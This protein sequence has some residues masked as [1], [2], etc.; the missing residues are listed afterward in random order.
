VLYTSDFSVFMLFTLF[1]VCVGHVGVTESPLKRCVPILLFIVY[2]THTAALKLHRS[3]FS[4]DLGPYTLHFTSYFSSVW[5][6]VIFISIALFT[7]LQKSM[8]LMFTY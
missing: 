5:S 8:M 4:P 3:A 2:V 1:S 7:A 6:Q